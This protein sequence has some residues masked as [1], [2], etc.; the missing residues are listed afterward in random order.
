MD[1]TIHSVIAPQPLT[2]FGVSNVTTTVP[3][4]NISVN[5]PGPSVITN[6]GGV[7]RGGSS[8]GLPSG[9]GVRVVTGGVSGA[10]FGPGTNKIESTYL[11]DNEPRR[12]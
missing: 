11:S 10:T 7:A 5:S 6:T 3:N 1:R 8:G 12:T 4:V 2:P 9:S